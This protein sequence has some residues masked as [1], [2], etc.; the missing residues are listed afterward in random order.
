MPSFCSM[1]VTLWLENLMLVTLSLFWGP[2]GAYHQFVANTPNRCDTIRVAKETKSYGQDADMLFSYQLSMVIY[3][4][5]GT[6]ILMVPAQLWD[7][8]GIYDLTEMFSCY[9]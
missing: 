6:K 5:I 2:Y 4:L 9:G 7:S 3:W 1:A 8:L